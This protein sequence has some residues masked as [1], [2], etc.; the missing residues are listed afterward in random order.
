V[1]LACRDDGDSAMMAGMSEAADVTKA[2][3][4]VSSQRRGSLASSNDVDRRQ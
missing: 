3:Q 4:T 2:E 1:L